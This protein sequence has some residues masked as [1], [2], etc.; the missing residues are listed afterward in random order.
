MKL[1]TDITKKEGQEHLSMTPINEEEE[2]EKCPKVNKPSDDKTERLNQLKQFLKAQLNIPEQTKGESLQQALQKVEPAQLKQLVQQFNQM[3]NKTAFSTPTM[4]E[5]KENCHV[6][7]VQP[8][9]EVTAGDSKLKIQMK[10][11]NDLLHKLAANKATN[12]PM[13]ASSLQQMAKN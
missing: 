6:P 4:G 9:K 8:L 3:Q 2:V 13:T 11:L 7:R 5:E 1:S 12:G 10:M